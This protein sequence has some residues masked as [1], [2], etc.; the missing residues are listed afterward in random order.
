MLR[1]LMVALAF[2]TLASAASAGPVA[3]YNNA[4][5]ATY[6]EYRNALFQSNTKNREA[7]EKT[8]AGFE[9]K[10]SALVSKYKSAPPPHF[11]DDAK[12]AESL[13]AVTAVIVRA[14][15]EVAKGDL[16]AT[17][18][19]LEKV[20][21]VLSDL[22]A[23]NGVVVYSDRVNAFHHTMEEVL[24]KPYGGLAGAGLTELVEDTAV[25]AYLASDMKK[26]APAAATASAE[27]A[28]ALGT[29]L[30]SVRELQVAARAGDVEKIKAARAKIKPAF[31]KLFLKFG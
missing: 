2:G 9:A 4:M 8:L 29:V 28:P 3:D 16:P 26:T 22:R 5:L 18:E 11:A 19:S 13:D 17:H 6:A 27:F 24:S 20:R 10:W 15:G 31:G 12:W 25:L 7:S 21:D 30:D 14:K 1:G 23:R